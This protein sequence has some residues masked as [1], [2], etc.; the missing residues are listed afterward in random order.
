[1]DEDISA[2]QKKW[3]VYSFGKRNVFR[4]YLNEYKGEVIPCKWTENRKGTETNSRDSGAR[5]LEAEIIR[6]RAESTAGCVKLKTVTE[7]RRS[8]AR[9]TFIAESVYFVLNSLLDWEP[10]EKLK[11]RCDMVSFTFF[12][13]MRRTAQF[14]MR[15]RLWTE[16]AGRPERRELQ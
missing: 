8:S 15:R 5:N 2:K 14:C 9:D 13:C 3:Q 12:F 10:V 7:I 1:M 11:Q 6:S 16:E 4:L